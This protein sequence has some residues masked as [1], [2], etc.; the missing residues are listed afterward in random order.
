MLHK[1]TPLIRDPIYAQPKRQ[2][3]QPGRLMLHAWRLEFDHPVTNERLKFEAP[4]PAEF[5]PW[6]QG[7]ELP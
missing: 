4:I 6:I 2:S 1:G 7:V 5:T 3:V